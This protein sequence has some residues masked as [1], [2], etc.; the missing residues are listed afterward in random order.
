MMAAEVFEAYLDALNA[1][2]AWIACGKDFVNH[3]HL[4]EAWDKAVMRFA[5]VRNINRNWAACE[6]FHAI[7]LESLE[8]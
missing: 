8:N 5:E 7:T 4:F 6:I 2:K 3:S 1:Y